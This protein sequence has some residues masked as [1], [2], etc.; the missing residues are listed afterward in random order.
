MARYGFWR[1]VLN[2]KGERDVSKNQSTPVRGTRK[3]GTSYQIERSHSDVGARKE[4][5][6]GSVIV[7]TLRATYG[8]TFAQGFSG[9]TKL[10]TVIRTKSS[11][12]IGAFN[13]SKAKKSTKISERSVDALANA[14]VIFGPALKRLAD[15]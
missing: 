12:A 7:T 8:D 6:D 13:E 15:R 11:A 10:T 3:K 5:K 2:V 1:R 9:H 14:S 4:R